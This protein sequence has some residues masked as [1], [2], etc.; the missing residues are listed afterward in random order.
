MLVLA[1]HVVR[2]WRRGEIADVDVSSR[3]HRPRVFLIGITAS[4]IA[5][6]AML[7]TH[8]STA[9]V[10]G[11]VVACAM[12]VVMAVLNRFVLKASLHSAFAT[13]AAGIVWPASAALGAVFGVVALAVG[14][15]RVVYG[16]H[17]TPE[18]LAGLAVGALA[19]G[20]LAAGALI[21]M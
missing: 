11:C 14:A 3:E 2:A 5:V 1:V 8:Q 21:S 15:S 17:T 16:R 18:V 6:A 4:A 20:A 10:R 13:M 7:A 9:V 12:L 19:A